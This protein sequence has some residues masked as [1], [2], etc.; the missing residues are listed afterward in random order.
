MNQLQKNNTKCWPPV[1]ET[2]EACGQ[3]TS[4]SIQTRN[5]HCNSTLHERAFILCLSCFSRFVFE[6]KCPICDFAELKVHWAQP[7]NKHEYNNVIW[8]KKIVQFRVQKRLQI[9]YPV[10]QQW[11]N[12]SENINND[13][14][15]TFF[16]KRIHFNKNPT[17]NIFKMPLHDIVKKMK[18][19]IV[20]R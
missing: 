4:N 7:W 14:F 20:R 6:I 8:L 3:F 13:T 19:L 2:N 1:H 15:H 17:C 12:N 5:G 11:C 9:Y 16:F 10:D 18:S